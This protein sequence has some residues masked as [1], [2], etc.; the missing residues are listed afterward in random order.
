M[1]LLK[2]STRILDR[3]EPLELVLEIP[4][5]AGGENTVG[6]DQELKVNEA[7]IIE[8]WDA[9]SLGGMIRSKG[10][11]SL[12]TNPYIISSAVFTGVG[13]NDATAGGTYTGT[14]TA[15]YTVIID[16]S[17]SS[18][19]TFKW[20][21]NSGSFT[22]GVSMTA[23]AHTLSDGITITFAATDGHT[24]ND[25]W[26]ITVTVYTDPA[27]LLLHH[28]E[29]STA[30]NYMLIHGN[31]F[32]INGSAIT[33]TDA[34]AFTNG[35]LTH[36]VTAGS[37]AWMTNSTDNLKYTT[38]AG[39]ITVPTGVPASARDRIYYHKQRLIA[40]GGG[41]TIYGSRAG[42]G[43]WAGSANT[44][45]ASGDA[46]SIDLPDL[47]QGLAPAFPS[48]DVIT[49]F[50]K[51]QAFTLYNFPNIAYKPVQ[52][53]HG[54][55]APY[56]IAQGTEGL[57]F[58]SQYPTLGVFLWDNGGNF[59]NLTI[60]EDW[61]TDINLSNRIFGYYREN[62]YGIIYSSTA[63]GQSYPDTWRIYDTKFGVWKSRPVNTSLGDNF[64]YPAVFEKPSNLLTFAS[65][66]ASIVYTMED[67]SNSDNGNATI[68]RYKTKDFTSKDFKTIDGGSFPIDEVRMKL[69]K[70][71]I[72]FYGSTGQALLTWTSD[73][74][75]HTGSQVF[76]L[77]ADQG[78]LLNTE[79]TVNSSSLASA[80]PDRTITKSFNNSAIGRRFSLDILNSATGDRPK[81]KKIKIFA[82]SLEEA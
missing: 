8:N 79:F 78:D 35:V 33:K 42:S 10:F 6:E 49:A 56:S 47:S 68:A 59:I 21:K 53:S 28:F 12:A 9:V 71:T 18:P 77:S 1:P 19:D 26:V 24:V 31:L 17:A 75:L 60:N 4:S 67:S 40:E 62:E 50:T 64:G 76:D 81:I 80:P 48:G 41:V 15:T 54:C 55:S 51:H 3:K 74:G 30:R 13:L 63:N 57:F 58:L 66:R 32:Y 37:K 14:V 20:K 22:T 70:T 34:S 65:S 25:Q 69:L 73:R 7:R 52:S 23:G 11:T 44:W 45:T 5:F 82:V 36:G 39:S 27:D 72:S 38:I 16:A 2:T 61:V 43:N 29:G 46:W